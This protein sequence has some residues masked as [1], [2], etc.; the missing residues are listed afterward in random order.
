MRLTVLPRLRDRVYSD[1]LM[2]SRLGAYRRLLKAVLR[3]GYQI[4]SVGNVWR[5]I[6]DGGLDPT[7]R[8]LVLRHDVDTDPR[9]AAAMWDIDRGLGVES[10]YFFRLS[11]LAP[12]LMAD[13]AGGG[14][15]VS[16]HYEE[17]SSVAKRRRLRT[18]SDALAALP[19]ARDL[20]AANLV[21]LRATTGLPM[22]VVAAHGDFVN[23]R[24]GIPNWRVVEEPVFR[25]EL[26]IDL[27]KYDEAFLRHL[28]SR[29][30]DAPP[31][32]GWEPSDPAAA[33]AAGVPVVSVL[34]H[35]RHWRA[36]PAVN[37][38]DDVRR[39]LEGVHYRLPGRPR[40]RP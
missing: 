27:E 20:F 23:R 14:S 36:A 26:G 17:L 28:P 18:A 11:T 21:R 40:W 22:R 29:H 8:H 33:I 30:I 6:G 2:G 3:A 31:P 34:V 39:V 24:L 32:V 16:Y 13:I 19:E 9:T 15:E 10:S 1:F 25:R 7:Q 37:A 35:P 38:R 12:A 4:S 5:L